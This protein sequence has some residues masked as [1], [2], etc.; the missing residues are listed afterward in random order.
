MKFGLEQA[1][2]LME[3]ARREAE[4]LGVPMVIAVAIVEAT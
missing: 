1:L 3:A 4:G 2:Q